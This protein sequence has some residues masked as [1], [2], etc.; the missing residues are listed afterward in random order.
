MYNVC[1]LFLH[2]FTGKGSTFR[3][4]CLCTA[5]TGLIQSHW[6][7]LCCSVIAS[8]EYKAPYVAIIKS[9]TACILKQINVAIHMPGGKK[10]GLNTYLFELSKY[11]SRYNY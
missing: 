5:L 7:V 9:G 11:N 1:E 2:G 3:I 6:L 8:E 10:V 4:L